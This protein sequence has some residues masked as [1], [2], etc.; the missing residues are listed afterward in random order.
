MRGLVVDLLTTFK[1]HVVNTTSAHDRKCAGQKTEWLRVID[2]KQP[3]KNDLL[4]V[5]QFSV[6][7]ALYTCRPDLVG[8]VNDL[9]LVVIELKQ[10]GVPA[11]AAFDEHL[12]HC[13]ERIDT[14]PLIPLPI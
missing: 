11:C 7:G 2:W 12:T 14:S 10:P 3:A 6:T 1:E 5:N 13:T 8:F 9:P 4:L